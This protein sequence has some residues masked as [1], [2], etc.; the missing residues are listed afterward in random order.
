MVQV[1]AETP[2][3]EITVQGLTFLHPCP[4]VEGHPMT[5]GEASQMNQVLGENLRNNFAAKIKS[6]IEAHKKANNI[7]DDQEIGADVLDKDELDQE[8][9]TLAQ[10]YEFG[11]RSAASGPRAPADPV[12]KEAYKIAWDKVKLALT[13]KNI[14]LDSVTKEQKAALIEQVQAKYP[15]I[16]EEAKRRVQAT[17]EI[18]LED[19]DLGQPQIT[20]DQPQE[21]VN[22]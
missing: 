1:T 11:V 15:E 3:S 19:V 17:A 7:P 14:K 22:V 21:Q 8:F 13:K 10:K 5:A 2:H 4:F 18:A 12:G 9:A 6:K 20:T 16:M